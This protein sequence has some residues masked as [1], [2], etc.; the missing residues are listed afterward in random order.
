MAFPSRCTAIVVGLFILTIFFAYCLTTWKSNSVKKVTKLESVRNLKKRLPKAIIIGTSKSGTRALLVILKIHPDVKA[1]PEEVHFFNREENYMLGLEW[2]RGRMPKSRADQLTIEK[3]PGYFTT[4]NVPERVYN[5]S[6]DIK[7]LVIV[8][9]PTTRAI[10]EYTQFANKANNSAL[11]KFEDYVTRKR[12][13][14]NSERGIVKSG[15]YINHLRRWLKFFPLSQI[16]FVSGE[17]LI[18]NPAAE[19]KPVEKFLHL[20]PLITEKNFYFNKTKGFPCFIG[21]IGS[22]GKKRTGC[23]KGSK[24]RRHVV[25]RNETVKLLQRYYRPYNHA[26]YKVVGRDFHWA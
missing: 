18:K 26:L 22:D 10:S 13:I 12:I 9:D 7:L 24:G 23:L 16:H 20:R 17:S 1:C 5:M 2:Y 21:K 3:S 11:P 6:K 14:V 8:R 19:I 4:K 15:V 25:V